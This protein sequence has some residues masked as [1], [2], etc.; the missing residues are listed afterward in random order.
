LGYRNVEFR[1]GYLEALPLEDQSADLVLSNCVLNLA[2]NKRRVFAEIL[3]VLK[4]GARLVISDV[5]CE[6]EPDAAIRNDESL[7]GECIAG[8][9]TQ[10]DLFGLLDEAGFVAAY[11]LKRF[12]YRTVRGH[13]FYSL[14]FE[15]TKPAVSVTKT[16]MY[17]GPAA[18]LVTASGQLLPA[19]VTCRIADGSPTTARGDL[20]EFDENGDV[21]NMA[22][23]PCLSC[24]APPEARNGPQPGFAQ[25]PTSGERHTSD[26][27][28]CGAPLTYLESERLIE[29]SYCGRSLSANAVCANG[30]FVCDACHTRDELALIEQV[31]LSTHETDMI[32]LM[33]QIRR[34]PS[35]PVH[36]PG[37]HALV[38]GVI[39]S[40]YRNLGGELS[41]VLIRTG[42]RRGAQVAG[43]ACGFFGICGAA[44]GVGIGF[45]IILQAN[46]LKPA[47]RQIVQTVTQRVLERIASLEAAR[48]CQRD[49]WLALRTAAELSAQYLPIPLRAEASLLCWQSDRN[50]ECITDRCPLWPGT[51]AGDRGVRPAR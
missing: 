7:R 4:P 3:R 19:G 18:A 49:C 46:P 21:T 31:C 27:M 30:H 38:P 16:V 12:P 6:T 5:V 51:G 13:R 15:A 33:A 2:T 10:R 24:A 9:L 11:A 25:L 47:A 41:D 50:A 40:T 29:C 44:T 23:E 20:F 8:A 32:A 48:C 34:H 45:S 35:V 36:G 14:T 39:L 1:K 42:I 37:H 26:C 43:G 22:V 28:V 17:R